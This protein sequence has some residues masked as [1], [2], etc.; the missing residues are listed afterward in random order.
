MKI[1]CTSQ[2]TDANAR[3][4][5]RFGRTQ[6]FVVYDTDTGE[7]SAADN[8]AG[9]TAAHGAGTQTAQRLF[10]IQ[11]DVLITGN[12]PGDK[13]R[14]LVQ[15]MSVKVYTGAANMTV[16]EALEAYTRGRLHPLSGGD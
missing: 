2:G 11:P 8:A 10:E 9:E 13:A 12:G 15:K 3:I 6:Y 7:Y 5:P 14:R 1:V 4:D 16:Q